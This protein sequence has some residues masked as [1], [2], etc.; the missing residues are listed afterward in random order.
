MRTRFR[1]IVAILLMGGIG[2]AELVSNVLTPY[3]ERVDQSVSRGLEFLVAARKADG[4]YDGKYGRST[5]VAALC[6]MAFLSAG[7]T[8]DFGPY[9]K[10]ITDCIDFC[11]D[12]QTED[13]VMSAKQPLQYSRMYAHNIST[14]FLL[15][16]SGMLDPERQRRVD[17]AIKKAVHIILAAQQVKKEGKYAGGWRY[18]PTSADSDFSCTGWAVMALR[19][20]RLNGTPV[21][22]KSIEDAVAYVLRHNNKAAG[23]FG[24]TDTSK[25]SVTLTGSGLLC[26]ELMGHH[27]DERTFS[28]GRYLLKAH[29][30]LPKQK[31]F[32]YGLYYTSQGMFQLG[33]TY[34]ATFA[35]WMYDFWMPKQ[36]ENGSWENDAYITAMSILAFTVPYRQL[37]IYQRDETVDEEPE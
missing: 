30:N 27:G 23:T 8:P 11:L 13:G 34:W 20:A 37:P 19:S 31:H 7:Y 21:P 22:D 24:Y 12:L 25:N 28:A 16:V 4:T 9:S 3:A 32:I 14:L 5:G 35:P 36:K 26:L 33:D 6:G 17:D 1:T 18:K 15:E 29:R 2:R 10:A